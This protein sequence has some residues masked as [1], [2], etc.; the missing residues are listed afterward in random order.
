MNT[1][2][3]CG[4]LRDASIYFVSQFANGR[5]RL[6][7]LTF[8]TQYFP[9]YGPS[10]N[11]RTDSPSMTGL[12]STLTCG[13]NTS[14]AMAYSEAYNQLTQLNEP[15]AL[16]IIVLFTDGLANGIRADF[17]VRMSQGHEVWIQRRPLGLHQHRR[18]VQYAAEHL[19]LDQFEPVHCGLSQLPAEV[20]PG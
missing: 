16:N 3:S 7:L 20:E 19:H 2:G 15:G 4:L 1:S 14:S 12:I 6:S 18:Y 9:A 17:P 10:M 11:F 8:G 13:M 5:D